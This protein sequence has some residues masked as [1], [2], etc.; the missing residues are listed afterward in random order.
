MEDVKNQYTE[1]LQAYRRFH[2][3]VNNDHDDTSADDRS[4]DSQERANLARDTFLTIFGDRIAR[5]QGFLI[6]ESEGTVLDRLLAWTR[7]TN[8]PLMEGSGGSQSRHVFTSYNQCSTRLAE[9]TST[10]NAR[11]APGVWPFI[12]KIWF[13]FIL[14]SFTFQN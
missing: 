2:L 8:A 14:L 10:S 9:F 6:R 1:L 5:D 4:V 7:E 11:Q 12:R 13:V 3:H